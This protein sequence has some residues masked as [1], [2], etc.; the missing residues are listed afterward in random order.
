M[1]TAKD[2]YN[3][4]CAIRKCEGIDAWIESD[5]AL[6]FIQYGNKA[7]VYA[8]EVTNKG[9][10]RKDFELALSERGFSCTYFPYTDRNADAWYEITFP[11]QEL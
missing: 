2:I 5:L 4:L 1:F 6:K 7:L 11:P 9:W 10:K 8:N 3:K